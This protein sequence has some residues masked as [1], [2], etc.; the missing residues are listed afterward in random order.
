MLVNVS[1]GKRRGGTVVLFLLL[2]GIILGACGGSET[3]VRQDYSNVIK[4]EHC[5]NLGA[6]SCGPSS[7][8]PPTATPAP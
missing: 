6:A 8:L 1:Q 3:P 7:S 5:S 2:L 4:A